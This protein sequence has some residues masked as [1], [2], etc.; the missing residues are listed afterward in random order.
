MLSI[1]PSPVP[2]A[3]SPPGDICTRLPRVTSQAS[4]IFLPDGR[5]LAFAEYG[6]RDGFPFLLFHGLPSS[7]LAGS[8]LDAGAAATGVRL[9]A[10]DRPGFGRSSP[11]AGRTI[12]DWPRD[13]EELADRLGLDRFGVVGISSALP[14][15]GACGVVLADRM[16][17]A[18]VFSG[19]GRL[20]I[21]GAL[22]GLPLSMRMTYQIGLG[23]PRRAA[24][25]MR[26]YGNA[27]RRMPELVLK[28]QLR[29][30]APVDREILRRP[31]IAEKRIADLREA[32][33]QGP[34]AA[35]LE[36][37]RHVEDWGYELA[38]VSC[39]VYLWSGALDRI[40]PEA[41]TRYHASAFPHCRTEIVAGAGGLGF[42][43]RL[44]TIFPALTP[45]HQTSRASAAARV[46]AP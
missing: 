24:I 42:L 12:L 43:D 34:A 2:L 1:V 45:S 25:W 21:D 22:Q 14:Y 35:A 46:E 4:E 18:A 10:P 13:V 15:V 36:A 20:D 32:F 17:V 37:R 6:D 3:L 40:H 38:D 39:P 44:D 19:L 9:I 29:M 23:S 8:M 30:M 28:Q 27:V 7:R 11:L 26:A 16:E 5:V 31:K 41:L 33:A